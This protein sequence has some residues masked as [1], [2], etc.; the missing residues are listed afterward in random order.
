MENDQKC[1]E[2]G[3]EGSLYLHAKCHIEWPPWAVITADVLTLE[4]S[5]CSKIVARFRVAERI[6]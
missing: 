3:D 1:D 2:C 5:N 4:C 6:E